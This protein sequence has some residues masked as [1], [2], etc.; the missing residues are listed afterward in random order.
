[1]TSCKAEGKEGGMDRPTWE[2]DR[3]YMREMNEGFCDVCIMI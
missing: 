3:M 1:M 2:E